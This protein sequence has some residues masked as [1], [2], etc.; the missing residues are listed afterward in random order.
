V[1]T[2]ED[3]AVAAAASVD[4]G[5]WQ[6]EFD[7][8]MARIAPRFARVEP[9]RHA[10]QL[11]LGLMAELPR[12]NCWTLAEHVG[13]ATPDAL[14]HLLGRAKWD[15]DAVRDDLRG[16]VME[17]L[18]EAGGVL[19]VDETGDVK[20][21]NATVGVQRQYTGTAGRI[22]NAQVAVYLVY[23]GRGACTFLDRA[24]YLPQCWT[25]DPERMAAA[26][27]PDD[28]QFATKPALA[29]QMIEAALDG[30][31]PAAYLTGDEVYGADT[32]LRTGLQERGLGYVLAVA[33]SHRVRTGIGQRRAIDLAVR[34]PAHAWQHLSAGHGAHGERWY[35]W[36]WIDIREKGAGCHGLL[37]RRH[38]SSGELAFYRTWTP[39]PVPLAELVRVAGIRWNIEEDF[40]TGKELTALDEHQVRRWT[41]WHRWT[42]LAMLAHAFL[43]VVTARQRAPEPQALDPHTPPPALIPLTRNEIRHLFIQLAH[44][45]Q[46]TAGFILGWSIWRRHRQ[47]G[48]RAA[49]YRR[50]ARHQ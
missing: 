33:R 1:W 8:L 10:R 9:R 28:T 39:H 29:R 21:G 35:D 46:H 32:A 15:A 17:H 16:Y 7:R 24:L 40:Q 43:T 45:I 4:P 44:H 30:G 48:A 47:S 41:S 5:G 31:V 6:A 22:E 11:V 2:S 49:H 18:G 12:L 36:T 14:Q 26:G 42:V 27:V 3:R 19:V 34:L 38:R 50:Q 23:A 25:S 37:I 20:K 13:H